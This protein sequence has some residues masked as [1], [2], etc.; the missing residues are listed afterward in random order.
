MSFLLILAGLAGSV[1]KK[2]LRRRA[3]GAESLQL[4]MEVQCTLVDTEVVALYT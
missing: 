1:S 4:F 2:P 3:G